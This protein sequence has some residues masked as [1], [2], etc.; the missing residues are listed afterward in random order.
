M[1]NNLKQITLL[2]LILFI[3]PIMVQ[4]K[5]KK[6][7][8]IISLIS[9]LA[10]AEKNRD[11]NS[12]KALYDENAIL[13]L[14]DLPPIYG[15][16][17]I[18]SLYKFSWK[19]PKRNSDKYINNS[20]KNMNNKIQEDGFYYFKHNNKEK[21]TA[22]RLILKKINGSFRIIEFKFGRH[23]LSPRIHNLIKPTGKHPIGRSTF[24]Y[25]KTSE[26]DRIVSFEL[27]YPAQSEGQ[28][29]VPYHSKAIT[30]ASAEFLG[31]PMFYNSYHSI[32]SSNSYSNIKAT[33]GKRFPIIVY[34]HGYS[35]FTSV[36]QTIFEELASHGYIV[37]SIAHENESAILVKDENTVIKTDKNNKF[38]KSH[39][40]ELN[41]NNN[42]FLTEYNS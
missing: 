40:A 15:I 35:G 2:I 31:W 34:H 37:V 6:E 41:G 23:I 32:I 33:A 30:R 18:I 14:T 29:K 26:K 39:S 4:S 7:E 13:F 22:Y 10:I 9:K 21:K 38:Y 27:W 8:K 17:A 25:D 20:I 12:I 42:Q 16:D 5:I 24:F 11:I 1:K 3:L 28:K 19:R 36:Y